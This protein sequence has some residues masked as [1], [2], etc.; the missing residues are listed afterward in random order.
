MTGA[1]GPVAGTAGDAPALTV[2][3]ALPDP[4]FELMEDGRP[5][6]FD[7]EL[8]QL[9]AARIGR[10]WRLELYE[11]PDF[12]GIFDRLSAG[13]YDCVASGATIT[14][15]R[16]KLADFCNPYVVSGQSLVVDAERLPN[17]RSI[18]DLQGLT[19][20]VQEGNTSQ[21]VAHLLVAEGKAARV[22]VYAYG[23]IERAMADLSHGFCDAFMKLAP[24]AAWFTRSRTRLQV[25][26]TG[27]THEL[28][29]VCVRRGD[30]ALMEA[31][32]QAQ[33]ALREDG[34]LPRLVAKW[35]GPGARV[36]RY[37]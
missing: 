16:R 35:L 11:A 5:A 14:P 36:S 31:I 4:P 26:Q 21:P 29:G 1:E 9:I 8:M 18:G 6:G 19:I 32:N 37:P 25:V 3:A 7:I 12:N 22:K 13:A 2:G 34:T 20:G 27:I 30:R 15:E 33:R 24:V 10:S 23:E 28:L 17:V